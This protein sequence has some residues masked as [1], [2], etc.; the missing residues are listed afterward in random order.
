MTNLEK[1][2]IPSETDVMSTWKDSDKVVVSVVCATFNHERYLEDALNGFLSQVTDFAFEIIVNDDASTDSTPTIIKRFQRLYPKIIKPNIQTTN[3]FTLGHKPLPIMLQKVR[4]ELI[5]MCEG[6]DFWISNN[7]LQSQVEV[8]RQHPAI[9]LCFHSAKELDIATNESELVCAPFCQ[10]QPV[11]MQSVILG[12]G[13]YM[14]TASLM[15]R[16][17]KLK[18]LVE[19]Y[20]DA[21]IGDYFIQVFMSSQ[22]GAYYINQ[23]MCVYRRN[24]IGSWTESQANIEKKKKYNYSMVEAIGVFSDFIGEQTDKDSLFEV[25]VM[26]ARNYIRLHDSYYTKAK[27]VFKLCAI[28]SQKDTLRLFSRCLQILLAR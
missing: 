7:K 1:I 24:A 14:P 11:D 15:Y 23:P 4:G 6:D 9:S 12:K 28:E 22:G 18:L 27:A 13:G 16:N 8:F 25:A 10:D 26:Y 5:A 19:S 3:Q 20:Q 2:S 21:P 17:V